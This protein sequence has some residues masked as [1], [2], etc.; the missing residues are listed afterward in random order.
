MDLLYDTLFNGLAI[1]S[2]LVLA[3]LGLAVVFGLMG[4]IN[5]AHGE[6]MTI[7]AYTI[8]LGSTLTEKFAPGWT[9]MYFPVAIVAA[10]FIAFGGSSPSGLNSLTE[11]TRSKVAAP[12]S[13]TVISTFTILSR[14]VTPRATRIASIVASVPEFV[15]LHIGSPYRSPNNSA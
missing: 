10:F 4:V 2:V 1:G 3:A 7:G 15:N 5:M 14:P 13:P 9:Q 12:G 11:N 6:F 8:Y